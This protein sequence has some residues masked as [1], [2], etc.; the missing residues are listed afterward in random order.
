M[1]SASYLSLQALS[2]MVQPT[3]QVSWKAQLHMEEYSLTIDNN[4]YK[5]LT[6]TIITIITKIRVMMR[7]VTRINKYMCP[8]RYFSNN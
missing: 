4:S 6:I 5:I 2:V 3:Q 8:E 1:L 7:N